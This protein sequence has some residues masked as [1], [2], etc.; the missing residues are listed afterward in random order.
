MRDKSDVF[1]TDGQW[2]LLIEYG[3]TARFAGTW[4]EGDDTEEI[5]RRLR[6]DPATQL[7][8]DLATAMRW[9]QPYEPE[10]IIWIGSHSPGWTHITS[11]SGLNVMPGPLTQDG[12]KMFYLEYNE[13]DEFQGLDYWRDGKGRG[14]YGPDSDGI[15][16][17]GELFDSNGIDIAALED[18]LQDVKACLYL[19]GQITGRSIDQGWLAATRTLYRIPDGAWA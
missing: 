19:M 11:I 4:V 15:G 18:D 14:R 2:D 7:D 16:E 8:C 13:I 9:Y 3:F 6:V 17:L 12:R 5:A 1:L 10:E